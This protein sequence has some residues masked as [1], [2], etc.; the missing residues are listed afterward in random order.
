MSKKIDQPLVS[1]ITPSYN[2]GRFIRATIESVL[3]QD[4]P[5]IE[6]IIIDG[7]STDETAAIAQ[8]YS[9]QLT[10]ISEPDRGQSHAINKGFRMAKGEIVAWLNS[11]DVI[12]PGAVTHAVRAFERTPSVGAVYGEGYQINHAGEIK[13][14]FPATEPFDLWKLIHV[15]DYIL[16]Q[17]VYFRR[18]IFDE[19]GFL[20]ES[21]YWGMDW[22]ILMRIGKRYW[23]EYIPEYMGCL[24]EYPEAKTFSGGH[25]RFRE[26]AKIMR[27]HGQLRYPPGYFSYG[28][29][30]YQEI[31]CRYLP[32]LWL[33]RMVSSA[34]VRFYSNRVL[35]GQGIYR[36]GW[37]GRHAKY[38]FPAGC[39][40]ISISGE[41]PD[42][43]AIKSQNLE[44]R[45][46]GQV[47]GRHSIRPGTF[48]I[49]FQAGDNGSQPIHIDIYADKSFVPS[50]SGRGN[51]SR[52]LSY[53]LLTI[54]LS[55]LSE[56]R[57]ASSGLN[58]TPPRP[59]IAIDD[60]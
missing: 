39:G 42:I 16:Q 14:R 59:K 20:D 46:N 24:R 54:E 23:I 52:R 44:I 12:L 27:R 34:A 35:H 2:Q 7:G 49:K 33:R 18:D 26:L 22:E 48:Q 5:K 41:L 6:Y 60:A 17:T 37:A 4:Y 55:D 9:E 30:T 29:H 31:I 11:D 10:F 56:S 47:V 38:M 58:W 32:T 15:S 51:D 53:R 3:G 57:G 50:Q 13:C 36:D 45:C 28:L 21:L 8:E 19:I 40:T 43:E 25:K 1:I